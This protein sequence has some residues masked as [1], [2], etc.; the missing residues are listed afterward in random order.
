MQR[1]GTTV[2][3]ALWRSW[4]GLPWWVNVLAAAASFL[5]LHAC[6]V[7]D[8]AP[9]ASP[10]LLGLYAAR[11]FLRSL[12]AVG[13]YAMPALL[14]LLAHY[15]ARATQRRRIAQRL[16]ADAHAVL[17]A[18]LSRREFETVLAEALQMQGYAIE[19]STVPEATSVD[20]ADIIARRD[21]ETLVVRCRQWEALELDVP[22]AFSLNRTVVARGASAG[23][24]VTAGTFTSEAIA[25]A[26]KRNLQLLSGIELVDMLSRAS[27]ISR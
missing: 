1:A 4:A 18:Q 8:I 25:F 7:E 12:A 3:A 22:E 20:D 23:I 13:Q 5:L 27:A 2:G 21:G 15:L 17:A 10:D 14:L 19:R 26:R 24:L 6:A 16:R 11:V 9:P